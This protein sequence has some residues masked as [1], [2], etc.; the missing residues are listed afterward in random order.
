MSE[1]NKKL[2]KQ[3]AV[4]NGAKEKK[5]LLFKQQS[6]TGEVVGGR[7]WVMKWTGMFSFTEEN[8][9]QI[10]REKQNI[11]NEKGKANA[12]NTNLKYW[13]SVAEEHFFL[14]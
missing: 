9:P 7:R 12:L 14:I 2:N 6:F 8:D 4:S 5:I 11:L 10:G 3:D 13:I 1:G